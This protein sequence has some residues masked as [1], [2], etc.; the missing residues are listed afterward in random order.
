MTGRVVALESRVPPHDHEY[1]EPAHDH[2]Y[3]V[4]SHDH[5]YASRTHDHAVPEH[6]HDH[7]HDFPTPAP[8][9]SGAVMAF[10]LAKCPDEWNEYERAYGRFIR[11]IDKSDSP[12]DPK[13]R[14]GPGDIQNEAFKAHQHET[15]HA[16]VDSGQVPG[17]G[18]GGGVVMAKGKGAY[19]GFSYSKY[20]TIPP[21]THAGDRE[22]RPDN[23]ALLYCV[24]S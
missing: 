8:V 19:V 3:A 7:A 5:G 11:G 15:P 23:V 2:E 4:P 21:T 18:D 16:V 13:G 20:G 24:K 1:A 14:R 17:M 9:P 22:T 12:V 6:E 10:D